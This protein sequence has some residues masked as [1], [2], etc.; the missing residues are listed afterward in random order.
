[1]GAIVNLVWLR[2]DLRSQDNS[3]LSSAAEMGG[4]VLAVYVWSSGQHQ[5]H[6]TAP[7]R[8]S[9]IKAHLSALS[10]TLADL[11]IP[12]HIIEEP[13]FWKIP[14]ALLAFAQQHGVTR[15]FFNDEYGEH[16]KRRDSLA[17]QLFEQD[18]REVF[19]YCDRLLLR[20]GSVLNG[21]GAPYSV[22]TP[23][24]RNARVMLE[25]APP[26]VAPAPMARKKIQAPVLPWSV[27]EHEVS[28]SWWIG[29]TKTQQHLTMF[30]DT[31]IRH[32]AE[33]RDFPAQQGTSLL[34]PYLALGVISPRQI[35]A[36]IQSIH[37]ADDREGA[38]KFIGELLWREFYNHLLALTPRLSKHKPFLLYTDQLPWS[39]NE[40]DFRA[41]CEARTGVPIVDAAMRELL[42]TGWMHNR[43]RMIVASFLTKN[44]FIDW[45]WG[46]RFFMQHLIDGDLA[47]NNGG[48]QWSASVGTDAAP[49]FRVFNPVTQGQRFDPDGD[50]IR[51]YM[52]ELAH[53][54]S[55]RLHETG[56]R[57]NYPPA[58][59]DLSASR[60]R[61]I[62]HF[63]QLQEQRRVRAG[64]WA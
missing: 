43:C 51:R 37:R 47:A 48:W 33:R 53:E 34:S 57:L 9:F 26:V 30:I 40:A 7:V 59:V 41:W 56:A 61:A 1:M 10:T 13:S 36:Q 19:H 21:E 16:E 32:Y 12:L 5:L 55:V 50:Y 60:A 14:Q 3:A 54:P 22:F 17:A 63:Q 28:S 15:L 6:D 49:Y 38:E 52:P 27:R 42:Q 20:P 46:E 45:R 29:E 24:A 35:F 8:L 4:P 62:A 2:N 25:R 44:L 18:G 23:Y 39:H 58:I 64:E 31:A 11:G